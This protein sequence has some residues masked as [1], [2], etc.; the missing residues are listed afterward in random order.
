[1]P[2]YRNTPYFVNLTGGFGGFNNPGGQVFYV[3]AS[4]WTAYR[5]KAPSDS[6]DGQSPQT[7]FSSIQKGLDSC[8]SGR[9][10]VVAVLPGSY[11]VTAAI[12]MTN[13]DVTLCSAVPVGAR[14]YGPVTI[15]NATDVNTLTVNANNCKVIGLVFDDNVAT[16]TAGTAAIAVNTGNDGVDYT[17][18]VIEN[19][20]ID[21]A[22]SDTDRDGI[23][24]GL[25]ADANDGAIGAIVRGCVI[26]DCE[27]DAIHINVG[28][29]YAIV[30]N[31]LIWDDGTRLTRYGVEVLA[32]GCLVKDCDISVSDTATAGA[33]VHNGVAA[34]RLRVLNCRLQA[35]GADTFGILAIATATQHTSANWITT[36]A[37]GNMVDYTTDNTTPSADAFVSNFFQ[38]NAAV[39]LLDQSTVGG[40]DA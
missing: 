33:C 13:D 3:G 34:A 35:M 6:N 31:C 4:G 19:C 11:T 7:A 22:G 2:S 28:S 36:V 8:V 23:T 40:A 20:W 15:V 14:S 1:M 16:A 5:G 37:A 27:Q 21:M 10:D 38:A 24:L 17:G 39:S 12:T 29:D 26:Y 32:V 18:V 25:T 9:G 30:D